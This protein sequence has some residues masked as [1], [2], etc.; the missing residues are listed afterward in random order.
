MHRR[1]WLASLGFA[2]FTVVAVG[3]SARGV[4]GEDG[5][6][7]CG[8]SACDTLKPKAACE[9]DADCANETL[10]HCCGDDPKE[11]HCAAL[12]VD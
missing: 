1:L 2:L 5:Y 4:L 3:A 10:T 9:K 11:F 8:N 6:P 12:P 7:C